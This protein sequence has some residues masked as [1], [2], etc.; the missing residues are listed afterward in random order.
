MSGRPGSPSAEPAGAGGVGGVGESSVTTAGAKDLRSSAVRT[1]GSSTGPI[2]DH[3]AAAAGGELAA[4][5]DA[6]LGLS[7]AE[8]D[9]RRVE[10]LRSIAIGG[11]AYETPSAA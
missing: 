9:S 3:E 10:A 5:P 4:L 2:S 7:G 1:D 6:P 11:S 8:R